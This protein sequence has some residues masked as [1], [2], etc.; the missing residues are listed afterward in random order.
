MLIG[1]IVAA[2]VGGGSPPSR[3]EDVTTRGDE[4]VAR[5]AP[6]KGEAGIAVLRGNARVRLVAEHD[7]WGE[8]LLPDGRRAW[9]PAA[10]LV[11]AAAPPSA[12]ASP[13][14]PTPDATADLSAA[15]RR[16]DLYSELATEI[17]RLRAVVDALENERHRVP[18]SDPEPVREAGG[19]PLAVG[20][21]GLL[22]GIFVGG[23][24]ARHRA[25]RERSIR[26]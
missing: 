1:G 11:H 6:G 15:E 13:T 19:A 23:A 12:A 8:I 17:A 7:G 5:E 4:I 24:W 20:G 18:A 26:F 16:P 9:V 10:D 2:A 22:V 21:V 3:A 25:R 14:A